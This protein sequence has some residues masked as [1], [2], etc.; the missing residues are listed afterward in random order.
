MVHSVFP[1]EIESAP[2]QIAHP[3]AFSP[4]NS[5]QNP[6]TSRLCIL[7]RT[8]PKH[9]T[10]TINFRPFR[11]SKPSP[12]SN[13]P[14]RLAFLDHRSFSVQVLHLIPLRLICINSDSL[15]RCILETRSCHAFWLE[16]K[17][18]DIFQRLSSAGLPTDEK[19]V[20]SALTSGYR[21]H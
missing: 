14:S 20:F 10:R 19:E 2:I 13:T 1:S 21:D 5:Y 7:I 17:S 6:V 4:V 18:P 12:F 11:R 15:S 9:R 16:L 8:T 3:R